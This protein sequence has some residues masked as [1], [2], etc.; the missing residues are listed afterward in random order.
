MTPSFLDRV[1]IKICGLTNPEDAH[2]AIAAGADALGFNLWPG[3][4]RC[5]SLE[6]NA[7]W[8]RDLPPFV[9]RVALLVNPTMEQALSV[10]AH[11]SIDVVQ[12]HGHE[13]LEFLTEFACAGH[14]FVV[15]IGL[16]DREQ[17][18]SIR[19]LPT[20]SILVDA[21]V[22]GAYGG[23]GKTADFALAK[24]L[25]AANRDRSIIL[26][27]GLTPENVRAATALVQPFAIDVASGVE[28]A[29]GRKD[30]QKMREFVAAAR[31]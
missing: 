28:S 8:I 27:G 25:V 7:P 10:A 3:S 15:A 30:A 19:A 18:T 26:A 20:R 29:P 2:A 9:T 16:K 6:D 17:I 23:T 12:F 31:I 4:K 13:S 14:P 24:E 1:R 11:P 22:P 5:I 21:V